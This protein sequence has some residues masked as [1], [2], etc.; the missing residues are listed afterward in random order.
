MVFISTTGQFNIVTLVQNTYL[1]AIFGICINRIVYHF[2]FNAKEWCVQHIFS[3]T[4]TAN[5]PL[6]L[7][8]FESK[9]NAPFITYTLTKIILSRAA[10]WCG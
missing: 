7:S 5:I 6:T 3:N 9:L 4:P 10:P 1:S 2:V 8:S